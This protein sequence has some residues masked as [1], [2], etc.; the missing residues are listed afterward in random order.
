MDMVEAL[1]RETKARV[2]LEHV[3]E[4]FDSLP[5]FPAALK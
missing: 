5:K 2:V 3:P 4:D 1:A